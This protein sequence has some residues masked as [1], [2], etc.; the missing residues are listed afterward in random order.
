MAGVHCR[1]EN[2]SETGE[3]LQAETFNVGD[4]VCSRK[5]GEKV[6]NI[7]QSWRKCRATEPE[8]FKNMKVWQSPTAFV[9]GVIWAW[10]QKEESSRFES[11]V[12]IV[13]SLATCWSPDS[14]Q[15]NFL[16]QT[17]QAAVPPGCT[18]LMQV[19]DNG[20]AMPAKAAARE[21][22]DRQKNSCS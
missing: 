7:M 15:R 10:Q 4:V 17:V 12:R 6:G 18:P 8:L 2:I 3:W 5:K 16:S 13:D 9:D 11:L 1:L 20:F 19:T 21:E 14:T 22:H